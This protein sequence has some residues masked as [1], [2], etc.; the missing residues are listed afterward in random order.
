M[1]Y[2][3]V[4]EF[5]TS[6][7]E[8]PLIVLYEL[9]TPTYEPLPESEQVALYSLESYDTVTYISCDSEVEPTWDLEYGTSKVGGYSLDAWNTAKRNEAKILAIE[10]TQ[11]T[12]E[13]V[14]E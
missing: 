14:T 8:S 12:T 13:E 10:T 2:S 5:K 3:T 11:T 4:D 1:R 6:L 9:A 7:Q